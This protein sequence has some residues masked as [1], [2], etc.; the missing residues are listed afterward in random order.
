MKKPLLIAAVILAPALHAASFDC[1]APKTVSERIICTDQ[2]VS[3]QEERFTIA[4]KKAREVVSEAD[5][6]T[7]NKQN[8]DEWMWR[9][10]NCQDRNC[11]IEWF[12]RRQTVLLEVIY[13]AGGETPDMN[14]NVAYQGG[15]IP[16]PGEPAIQ[17]ERKAEAPLPRLA[18]I[19][20]ERARTDLSSQ[21]K[22]AIN[23]IQK[24]DIF[25]SANKR[26][27]D[28]IQ[29]IGEVIDSWEGIITSIITAHGG[30]EVMVRITQNG[31]T[32]KSDDIVMGS[33]V[34][35]QLSTLAEGQHVVFSGRFLRDL[36][37]SYE[38]SLTEAGS[39]RAPAYRIEL[40]AVR[41]H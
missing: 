32:Y 36:D 9:E 6:P 1:S 21:Y 18:Q 12:L 28:I 19:K 27:V 24:S 26:T 16:R 8:K 13:L 22:N 34:Y 39:L 23:D 10:K 25:N 35:N 30:K 15:S 38:T 11:L 37:G 41:G 2:E 3:K 4:Y 29:G 33:P 7:F 14:Q 40:T 17:A 20:L 5:R 31:N